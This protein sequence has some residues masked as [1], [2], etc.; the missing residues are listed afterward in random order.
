ML[1]VLILH[2][3]HR[4][5]FFFSCFLFLWADKRFFPSN[6]LFLFE[7][8]GNV[9]GGVPVYP[10]YKHLARAIEQCINSGTFW[11][12]NSVVSI[13]LDE[14]LKMRENEWSKLV[15]DKGS[16][17]LKVSKPPYVL[18]YVC[19]LSVHGCYYNVFFSFYGIV[20]MFNAAV[21]ELHVQEPFFSQL[22]GNPY[23]FLLLAHG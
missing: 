23:L 17:L 20:Q 9:C 2:V 14:S 1:R 5:L 12:T 3:V 21:F 18:V 8:I 15:L 4:Y 10:L 7:D 13:P 16:E 6:F 22:R 11:R 19:V